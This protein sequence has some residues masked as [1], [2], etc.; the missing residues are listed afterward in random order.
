MFRHIS[1]ETVILVAV[2]QRPL[3]VTVT[4]SLLVSYVS[5]DFACLVYCE[6]FLIVHIEI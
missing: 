3:R 6:Y 5:L 1:L 2:D 4:N